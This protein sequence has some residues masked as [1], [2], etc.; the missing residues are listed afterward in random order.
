MRNAAKGMET[1]KGIDKGFVLLYAKLSP[2][3]KGAII[4]IIQ[5]ISNCLKW[6]RG[7]IKERVDGGKLR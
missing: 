6:K 1:P 3:R 4:G 5:A 2:R 7:E